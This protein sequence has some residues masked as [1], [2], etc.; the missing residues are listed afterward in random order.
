MADRNLKS[1]LTP[2]GSPPFRLVQSFQQCAW[3]SCRSALSQPA[4]PACRQN[5]ADAD[6]ATQTVPVRRGNPPV[7]FDATSW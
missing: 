4:L 3:K 5:A 6:C 7:A 1:L 2:I